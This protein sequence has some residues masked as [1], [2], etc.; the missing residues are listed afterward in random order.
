MTI[1]NDKLKKK[2]EKGSTN[3]CATEKLWNI[4]TGSW[5]W[6]KETNSESGCSEEHLFY[7]S[8]IRIPSHKRR[9]LEKKVFKEWIKQQ[10][11]EEKNYIANKN[12]FFF[13]LLKNQS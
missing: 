4:E 12:V 7:S 11:K 3:I 6:M 1:N 5:E 8:K 13:Y 2:T 9:E 10:S